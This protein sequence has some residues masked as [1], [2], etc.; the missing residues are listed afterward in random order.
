MFVKAIEVATE[1]TRPLLT[2]ERFYGSTEVL[3]GA[4]SLFFVNSDGWALTCKHVANLIVGAEQLGSRK[5]QFDGEFAAMSGK[6]KEKQIRRELEQKFQVDRKK[7]FEIK[8]RF[9]NCIEGPTRITM[10][11]H[12]RYDVAVLHFEEFTRLLCSSFPVFAKNG[13]DLKQG[14]FLCRLGFPF[15][16]FTNYRYDASKDT[17][18][19][20]ATGK[21]ITPIFPIEGML[22][23]HLVDDQQNMF[24]F[25]LST[26]GLRGQSGCPVFDV[27]G[28]VWG[29]Q[30]A[31]NHLDL[32]FDV[33]QE[34]VRGGVK[35]KVR[36]SAFLHVG[37]CIHVEVLKEFLRSNGVSFEEA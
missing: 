20:T 11:N 35:K 28:R 25:E 8:N 16:E 21:D 33:D 6:K 10:H 7:V 30:S 32:N 13:S 19:W 18:E 29:M 12:P 9:V 31:T 22:T 27:D 34:V 17:I 3:R 4:S 26:P 14:K 24:G 15:P 23:R 5:Q 2:I 37:H 1:F 36:D